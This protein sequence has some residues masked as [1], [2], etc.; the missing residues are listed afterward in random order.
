MQYLWPY[1]KKNCLHQLMLYHVFLLCVNENY[2]HFFPQRALQK[3]KK[4]LSFKLRFII[5]L[6]EKRCLEIL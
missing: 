4:P 3:K 6:I 2:F 5:H 1:E